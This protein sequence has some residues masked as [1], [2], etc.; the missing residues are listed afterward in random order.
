MLDMTDKRH[1]RVDSRLRSDLMMWLSSVR[2]DGRAHL[3]P[4]WFLWQ[5]EVIYI[6][7]KPDQKV[8][9]LKQNTSA[10]V[11]IDDTKGG[12]DPMMLAGDVELM[13]H[14]DLPAG[15]QEAYAEKYAERLKESNWAMDWY[16][17]EYSE[18]IK[19]TPNKVFVF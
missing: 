17:G 18:V 16:V 2:P 15:I 7:S 9:N 4:V 12:N 3:V 11:G 1:A 5:D 8:R 13:K 14:T 6:F 19:F 10:M